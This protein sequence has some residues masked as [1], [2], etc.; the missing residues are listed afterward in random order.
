MT[1]YLEV[2]A[3]FSLRKSKIRDMYMLHEDSWYATLVRTA[4]TAIKD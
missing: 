2:S 3:Y 4:V 1:V